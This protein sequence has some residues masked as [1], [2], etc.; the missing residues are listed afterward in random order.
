VL[1][2]LTVD[3]YL[4][5]MS[6]KASDVYFEYIFTHL[7]FCAMMQSTVTEVRPGIVMHDITFQ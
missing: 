7:Q 6:I 4:K 5:Q 1:L 3:L 2:A